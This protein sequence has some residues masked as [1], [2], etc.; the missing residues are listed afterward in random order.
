MWRRSTYFREVVLRKKSEERKE[1]RLP[2][3]VVQIDHR[4]LSKKVMGTV[5]PHIY[6]VFADLEFGEIGVGC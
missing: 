4:H 2:K 6:F 3:V 5:D 1:E